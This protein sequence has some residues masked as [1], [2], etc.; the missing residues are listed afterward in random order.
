[1]NTDLIKAVRQAFT[2]A[3]AVVRETHSKKPHRTGLRVAIL[4]AT[5]GAYRDAVATAES[6]VTKSARDNTLRWI[7]VWQ[8]GRGLFDMALDTALRIRG[9]TERNGQMA[10]LVSAVASQKRFTEAVAIAERLAGVKRDHAFA[11]IAQSL[12]N[13]GDSANAY[14]VIERIKH[15]TPRTD[16]ESVFWRQEAKNAPIAQKVSLARKIPDKR[17][18]LFVLFDLAKRHGLADAATLAGEIM[19]SA[20]VSF[21]R[22]ELTELA[23]AQ[24]AVGDVAGAEKTLTTIGE[25]FGIYSPTVNVIAALAKRGNT[26]DAL[27][28]VRREPAGRARS[29]ALTIPGRKKRFDA[30]IIA[31]R[32]ALRTLHRSVVRKF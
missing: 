24:A 13:A 29:F 2:E 30:R 1:M 26:E 27:R 11:D 17:Q 3:L 7:V 9:Q 6:L 15:H 28:L 12:Q 19:R 5:A 25:P 4:Q 18:Q 32:C 20:P 21:A 22:Y 31:V 14:Q 8:S 10:R 16:A 23:Q